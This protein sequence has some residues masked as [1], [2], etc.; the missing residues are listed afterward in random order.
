MKVLDAKIFVDD[1][2]RVKISKTCNIHGDYIDT[3]T[4]SDP[5]LY[6]WAEKYEQAGAPINNP[7]TDVKDGCP[8]DCGIC[9][10]HKSHTVLSIIDIT[11][12]CNL[13][14]PV[15]FAN[16]ATAGYIYEPTKEQIEKII[17][18]LR[19]NSPTPPPAIQF[20][21]GEPTVRQ[22]L[23]E[24]VK[25][26]KENGFRHIEVNTN[27]VV[28]AKDLNFFKKLIDAGMSTLYLQFDGLDD[29]IYEKTRG[30]PLLE[31]KMKVIDNARKLG[32]E[33]IVLVVT[34]VRGINDQQ[35]GKIVNF[36]LENSEIVR[37]VNVQPVSITGRIDSQAREAMRINTTD[38]MEL[39]QEQ[40]EGQIKKDD[41]F[42][43]PS[44]I[45][46][47]RTVGKMK[48]K[49]YS[50]FSTSPWCGIGTFMVEA[51][52]KWVPIT[53]FAKVDQFFKTMDNIYHDL[54]EGHKTRA[55]IRSFA[56]LRHVKGSFIKDV[57]WPVMKTGSYNELSKFMRNVVMIGCMH[58][59]DPYNF[60]LQRLEKC[61]IHYG[62]PDGTIRPF[63]SVNT[64]HRQKVEK[65]YSVPY[66][67]QK[68][69]S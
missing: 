20:S 16:A 11:N 28:L 27:G 67:T 35:I 54:Q 38:F 49:E 14:C 59:M 60:D 63:C 31:T 29:S 65:Q 2:D 37:C 57:L 4:F 23:P 8:Y 55:K 3:Y 7:R 61:V 36:A 18:N 33:S 51:N 47:A 44:V 34:L 58:F 17:K 64:L 66:Q 42:P 62:L 40:T 50:L 6:E 69:T 24:L 25:L 22:D 19:S 39:I 53:R 9:P 21:G 45:P 15:C 30:L 1:D 43:V 41:F 12:R 26:A 48:S 68:K 46:F 52:K 13:T 56:A 32:F 5:E 10:N